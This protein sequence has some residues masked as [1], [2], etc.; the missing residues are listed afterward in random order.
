MKREQLVKLLEMMGSDHDGEALN[1]ARKAHSL[2]RSSGKT[3]DNY[4]SDNELQIRA[5]ILDVHKRMYRLEKYD[6][7][8][9]LDVRERYFAGTLTDADIRRVAFYKDLTAPALDDDIPF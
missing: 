8:F 7:K 3:W 5:L 4:I 9:F 6:Q 2:V 1:A